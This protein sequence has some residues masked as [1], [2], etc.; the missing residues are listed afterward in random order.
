MPCVRHLFNFITKSAMSTMNRMISGY[1]LCNLLTWF[2]Q[3]PIGTFI[4]HSRCMT[5]L[6]MAR[7]TTIPQSTHLTLNKVVSSPNHPHGPQVYE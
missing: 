7:I 1:F 4:L 6:F 3:S 5:V 2:H